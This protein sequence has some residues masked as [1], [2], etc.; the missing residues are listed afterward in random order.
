MPPL[1][2]I[3]SPNSQDREGLL[4]K[5]CSVTHIWCNSRVHVINFSKI[6]EIIGLMADAKHTVIKTSSFLHAR[7]YV[8][9]NRIK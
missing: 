4:I 9:P 6:N 1:K 2:S 8:L 3:T 7:C 5:L